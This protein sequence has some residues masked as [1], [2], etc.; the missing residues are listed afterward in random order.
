MNH[1]AQN[2][3]RKI[4]YPV[5]WLYSLAIAIRNHLF[6]RQILKSQ[7]F[8]TATIVVGNITV[9]GTGKT[10]MIEYLID[11][12]HKD[13]KLAA[14]S[15][16]YGRRTKGYREA[17]KTSN[18][19][20][21]G[22]EPY[23]IYRKYP[24][25]KVVVCANRCHAI[26]VIEGKYPETD[27]VLLDDAYQHRYVN[28]GR[29]ILLIDYNRSIMEDKLMPYGNLREPASER[30]RADI[31]VVTKCPK[32]MTAFNAR[33]VKNSL[34]LHAYQD[35]F[36]ATLR[37]SSPRRITNR[38]R[39]GSLDGWSVLLVTAIANPAPLTEYLETNCASVKSILFEDH[40]DFNIEDVALISK[41]FES[42]ASGKKCI[43]ITSKDESKLV[44]LD[45]SDAIS[46]SMYVI[47]VGI[48]FLF[49]TKCDFDKKIIGYVEKNKRN[50]VLFTK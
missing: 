50:S 35:L 46:N 42:M 48:D 13:Y 4:L 22:D 26:K 33:E 29:T 40:H 10:P 27:A 47:D 31:V 34:N 38:V 15:R 44:N 7:S 16:G 32:D 5:G 11:I 43:V 45:I 17:D 39:L 19:T 12:L 37:Y 6:D 28:A 24:D 41:E 14:L 23:Q 18:A 30:F 9:G 2:I 3:L 1:K 21:I 36:F 25:V 20:L 8:K 49:D